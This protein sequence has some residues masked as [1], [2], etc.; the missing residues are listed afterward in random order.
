MQAGYTGDGLRAWKS[1][2]NGTTYFVYDGEDLLA[3]TDANGNVTCYNTWG[4]G[5]LISRTTVNGNTGTSTFYQFDSEGN[6]LQHLDSADNASAPTVYDAWGNMI[7][8]TPSSDPYGY[9][10]EFG[11]YTDNETGL[12]L[13]THRYYDPQAGRWL[14]EDPI[15]T[16]GGMNLYGYCNNDAINRV[17]SN[18]FAGITIG[19]GGNADAGIVVGAAGQ[20][21]AQGGFFVSKPAHHR[22]RVSIGGF[23]SHGGVLNKQFQKA[24]QWVAGVVVGGG[25]QI[26]LTNAKNAQQLRGSF[27]TVNINGGWIIGGGISIGK[28][29]KIVIV[30]I[31][32]PIGL[33]FGG[34]V[35]KYKTNTKAGSI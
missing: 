8:G 24:K 27:K 3:E 29:G 20:I 14:T 13:C 4:D 7:A 35:S 22:V 6:V 34:A 11:Y 25:V 12:I 32:T 19:I 5:D 21:S 10:G 18:G 28:S 17:D 1:N 23:L 16:S 31:N 26:S 33:T 30:T 2:A 9:K 15:G